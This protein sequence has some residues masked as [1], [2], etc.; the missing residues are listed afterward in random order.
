MGMLPGNG[1]LP[2][3]DAMKHTNSNKTFRFDSWTTEFLKPCGFA[4]QLKGPFYALHVGLEI[5]DSDA[6]AIAAFQLGVREEHLAGCID[7]LEEPAF[8]RSNSAS[9]ST[10]AG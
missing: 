8:K 6:Q 3:K 2:T 5:S 7:A 9:L 1:V 4:D 10:P